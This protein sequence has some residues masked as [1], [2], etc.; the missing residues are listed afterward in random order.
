MKKNLCALALATL[1]MGSV[2][3]KSE[4][5]KDAIETGKID[6]LKT[7]IS[8]NYAISL[9]DKQAFTQL[10]Q[11][12]IDKKKEAAKKSPTFSNVDVI[13]LGITAA[14]VGFMAWDAY[15]QYTDSTAKCWKTRAYFGLSLAKLADTAL[16]FY[17]DS[18]KECSKAQ[19]AVE[20]AEK[21]A[22][23]LDEINVA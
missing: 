21:V 14:S 13:S 15:D 7:C 16:K 3:A 2:S 22:Q 6:V 12:M 5:L 10:A 20:N 1:V 11:Q 18:A 4:F 9:K 23:T 17:K 8:T 19:D